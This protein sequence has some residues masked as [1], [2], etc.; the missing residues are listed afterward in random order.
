MKKTSSKNANVPSLFTLIE[1]LVVIAII[2]ILAAM[3]LP[4]LQQARERGRA[5]TCINNLKQLGAGFQSYVDNNREFCPAADNIVTKES[6]TAR[7]YEYY[8]T[9]GVITEKTMACPTSPYSAFSTTNVNYGLP[10]TLFGQNTQRS[11]KISS[12]LLRIPSRIS[13]AVETVPHKSYKEITGY[14]NLG[15]Y[16]FNGNTMRI[17]PGS[18]SFGDSSYPAELRHSSKRSMN[19]VTVAGNVISVSMADAL[20]GCKYNLWRTRQGAVSTQNWDIRCHD[21]ASDCSY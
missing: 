13:T 6:T 3:L 15:A 18:S 20:R 14:S 4:A 19:C 10:Y 5:A 7:W 8:K 17:L 9:E 11:M 2:A 21:N 1:L 12:R 16:L